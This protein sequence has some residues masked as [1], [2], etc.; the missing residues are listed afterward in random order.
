M[1][2]MAVELSAGDEVSLV[3]GN[4]GFCGCPIRI[5]FVIRRIV[6][7]EEL[8]LRPESEFFKMVTSSSSQSQSQS[9]GSKRVFACRVDAFALSESKCE[10][11]FARANSLRSQCTHILL[12]D[13]PV[14]YIRAISDSETPSGNFSRNAVKCSPAL[15]PIGRNMDTRIT[16]SLLGPS[17]NLRPMSNEEASKS[18]NDLPNVCVHETAVVDNNPHFASLNTNAVSNG[19]SCNSIKKNPCGVACLPPGRN[20]YLNRL[21]FMKESSSSN[22]TVISL[23]ELLCPVESISRIFVATFTCDILWYANQYLSIVCCD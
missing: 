13:D 20:F 5:G 19:C 7:E 15:I 6:F 1:T 12:S 14:S 22:H 9:R 18:S 23:P 21:G 16:K 11:L 8:P 10:S 17:S 4:E 3:C 2:G